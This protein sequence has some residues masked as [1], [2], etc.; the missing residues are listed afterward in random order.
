[1]EGQEK[2][3]AKEE[4]VKFC[5]IPEE[6]DFLYAYSTVPGNSLLILVSAYIFPDY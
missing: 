1:M 6:A 4:P 2:T 3:D 5:R